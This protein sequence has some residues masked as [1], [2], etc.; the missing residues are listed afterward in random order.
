MF[1]LFFSLSLS[2]KPTRNKDDVKETGTLL[3]FFS[4]HSVVIVFPVLLNYSYASI[5]SQPA[6]CFSQNLAFFLFILLCFVN[7]AC[8]GTLGTGILFGGTDQ[9]SKCTFLKI[10]VHKFFTAMPQKNCLW[11]LV[12]FCEMERFFGC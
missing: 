10:K 8:Q 5:F 12:C 4:W 11:F 9:M 3:F 2:N 1:G 7:T 6:G